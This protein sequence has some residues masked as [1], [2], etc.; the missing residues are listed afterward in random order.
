M[1]PH[2][3]ISLQQTRTSC[4]PTMMRPSPKVSPPCWRWRDG[5]VAGPSRIG[6]S[7]DGCSK[8]T[9]CAACGPRRR[10]WVTVRA[11]C[12]GGGQRIAPAGLRRCSG[13]SRLQVGEP[14][15]APTPG[16]VEKSRGGLAG[17]PAART[18]DTLCRRRGASATAACM[19]C[20]SSA[21]DIKPSSRRDADVIG[22]PTPRRKPL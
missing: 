13:G 6:S 22:G 2:R 19:G 16:R 7:C 1:P 5:S 8:R 4:G 12:R 11:N 18:G 14:S 9:L 21:S 10:C 15:S 20:R 3:V 17:S